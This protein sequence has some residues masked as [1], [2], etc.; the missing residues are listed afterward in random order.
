MPMTPSEA[1]QAIVA[2]CAGEEAHRTEPRSNVAYKFGSLET[3]DMC[4]GILDALLPDGST[5]AVFASG[6]LMVDLTFIDEQV[7]MTQ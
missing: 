2:L 7:A 3:A 6:W 1:V 4:K 5:G